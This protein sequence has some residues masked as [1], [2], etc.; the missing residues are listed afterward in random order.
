[1]DEDHGN[2]ALECRDCAFR[3]AFDALGT[4]RVALEEH[5]SETGHAVDWEIDRVAPGVEQAGADAGVCGIPGCENPES[6]LLEWSDRE[7]GG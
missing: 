2:V 1:M 5:E 4:A 6:A 3:A 7:D